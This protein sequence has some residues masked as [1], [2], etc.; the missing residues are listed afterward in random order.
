MKGVMAGVLA[1]STEGY[2]FFLSGLE[3]PSEVLGVSGGWCSVS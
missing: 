1:E 2:S 3:S